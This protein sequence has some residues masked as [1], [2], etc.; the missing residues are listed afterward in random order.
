MEEPPERRT[1]MLVPGAT[2]TVWPLS[3]VVRWTVPDRGPARVPPPEAPE[4]PGAVGPAAGEELVGVPEPAPPEAAPAEAAPWAGRYG[5]PREAREGAVDEAGRLGEWAA[6][7][8]PAVTDGEAGRTTKSAA[9][10]AATTAAAASPP[11]SCHR[12]PVGEGHLGDVTGTGRAYTDR[13]G[14]DPPRRASRAAAASSG[15]VG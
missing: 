5:D 14:E 12:R 10:A 4:E 1:S 2:W 6:P 11:T 7:A 8:A 9:M 3:A 15:S 13:A